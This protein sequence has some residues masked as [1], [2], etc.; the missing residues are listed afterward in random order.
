MYAESAMSADVNRQW[1]SD[2]VV[3]THADRHS[4]KPLWQ[5]LSFPQYSIS[6]SCSDSAT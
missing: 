2:L 5:M 1:E 3:T 6:A 4:A